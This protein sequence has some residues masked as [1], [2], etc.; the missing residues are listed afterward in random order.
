MKSLIE[1]FGAG[2]VSTSNEVVDFLI[3]RFEDLT[4]KDIP[5]FDKYPVVG[6]KA[7]DFADW[8]KAAKLMKNKEHLTTEGLNQICLLNF[9][10]NKNRD[11]I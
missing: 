5:F 1:Y 7:L 3:Q 11:D 2:S 6:I 8:C 9:G 10:V 4:D